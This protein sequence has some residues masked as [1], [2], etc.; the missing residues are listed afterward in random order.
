MDTR[1]LEMFMDLSR[2]LRFRETSRHCH[3]TP[4]ALTRA[5]LRLE[6]EVGGRLFVRNRRSVRLTPLGERFRDYAHNAVDQWQGFLADASRSSATVRGEFSL[7]CSVT[8]SYCVLP[9]LLWTFRQRHPDVAV[10]LRTGDAEHGLERVVDGDVDAALVPVPRR[11]PRS[12]ELISLLQTPLMLV[13]P[14]RPCPL[15]VKV[16]EQA[17]WTSLPLILPETGPARESIEGYFRSQHLRPRILA[18]A[19]GNEAIL[20]MASLGLGL[21]IVPRLVAEHA[22]RSIHVRYL[23]DAPALSPYTIALCTRRQSSAPPVISIL[24]DVAREVFPA[25][26]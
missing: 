23:D 19:S 13:A 25:E 8:A 10:I 12:V 7:Y 18:Y 24:R 2:T 11:V 21:G 5:I 14:V 15:Q 16:S 9:R 22:P 26:G 4:S 3:L 17:P 20:S 6:Q 1:V